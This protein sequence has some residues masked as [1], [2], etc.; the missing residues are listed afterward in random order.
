MKT[1]EKIEAKKPALPVRK[2]VAAYAR[3]SVESERMQH[4]LSAQVSYYS[5]FIQKNPEWEYAGVYKGDALLQKTYTVDFLTK[6]KKVNEG[7]IP[8]YYVRDNHEAIIDRETFEMVQTLMM[9]RRPGANRRSCVS[10]FSSR[11]KCADC[12]GWYGPKVWHSN[13]LYRGSPGEGAG[14]S[15]RK[16]GQSLCPSGKKAGG[17]CGA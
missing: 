5:A 12:G 3:V 4:S 7:E 1:V 11:I 17:A 9:A 14:Y 2:R 10:V 16:A 8:Q 15:D 6:K 13:D